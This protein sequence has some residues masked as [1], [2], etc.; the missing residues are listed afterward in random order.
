MPSGLYISLL[1]NTAISVFLII[2]LMISCDGAFAE[3]NTIKDIQIQVEPVSGIN[4]EKLHNLAN[5]IISLKKGEAFSEE[6]LESSIQAIKKTGLFERITADSADGQQNPLIIFKLKPARIIKDIRIKGVIYPFFEKDI[7]N[8]MTIFTGEAFKPKKFERQPEL[9][10]K[11]IEKDGFIKPVVTLVR[12]TDPSDGNIIIDVMIK[13]DNFWYIGD[14]KFKGN[15]SFSDFRLGLSLETSRSSFLP[16]VI[17]RFSEATLKKEIQSLVDFYRRNGF[18]DVAVTYDIK[19]NEETNTV[20]VVIKI[21]EGPKYKIDFKGNEHYWDL[22]LNK[23]VV[24][25]KDGNKH[26]LGVRKSIKNIKKRYMEDGFQSISVTTEEE[27]L[28]DGKIKKLVFVMDEGARTLVSKVSVEGNQS[29]PEK[30]IEKNML[31]KESGIFFKEP[32]D[33]DILDGDAEAVVSYYKNQGFINAKTEAEAEI[34]EDKSSANVKMIIDENSR[35]HTGTIKFKGLD[36][37]SEK[38]AFDAINTKKGG[39]FS[40]SEL[41][42]DEKKISAM[43]SEKGY[44]HVSV[45][46][47]ADFNADGK[48]VDVV[49]NVEQ[50]PFVKMGNAYFYGNVRTSESLLKKELNMK[51]GEPFSLTKALEAQK[52]IRNMDIFNSVQFTSLGLAEKSDTVNLLAEIEEKKPYYFQAGVGYDSQKGMYSSAKTGDRNL[53]GK[54]KELWISGEASQ[55]T[56]K[57][58]TGIADPRFTGLRFSAKTKIY[59]EQSEEFNQDFGTRAFGSLT[60]FEKKWTDSIYTSTAMRFEQRE[61]YSIDN[62]SAAASKAEMGESRKLVAITP[63]VHY[64]IRDSFIRPRKGMEASLSANFSKSI[65]NDY[66]TFRKYK[67]DISFY[68]SPFEKLTLALAGRFGYIDA[69]SDM[70]SDQ[71]FY[72]GGTTSVRGYN[73][74]LLSTDSN[75]D[76]LGGRSSVSGTL[77]ARIELGM[78]FE[79]VTF[80]DTGSIGFFMG[81]EGDD[82]FKSS[83]GAGIG[84]ITPIGPFSLM[85]GHKL[86]RKEDEDAGQIHFS[87]GYVF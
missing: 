19:K 7:L 14:I 37:I 70:P 13:K 8:S 52:N 3:E 74:N 66:D 48:T 21:N 42:G 63:A 51:A 10:A 27:L 28:E 58:E 59:T 45:K 49:F 62:E 55:T 79:I 68:H 23:D 35:I 82:S 17:S 20:D 22:T 67:F 38:E 78:K 61:Q 18:A 9:I 12:N 34:S 44:P 60:E 32:F 80:V 43:I 47:S 15:D 36:L 85:Y 57:A 30:E 83:I 4:T 84:Y 87:V 56:Y 24:I 6:K 2:S 1:R 71:L 39:P 64:D 81:K 69:E 77:E 75:G 54:N 53:F 86:D 65:E 31:T 76:A 5:D 33:Q 11:M 73:E 25:E 72:L 41:E 29:V 50:G 46:A 16:D 40:K 26:N